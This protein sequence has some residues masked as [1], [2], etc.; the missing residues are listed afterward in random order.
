MGDGRGRAR[1]RLEARRGG[2]GPGARDAA[3]ALREVDMKRREFLAATGGVALSA[4]SSRRVLG[5][6]DRLGVALIGSGRR[7]REV[8]RAFLASGRAELRCVADV[9]DVQRQRAREALGVS[10]PE[11]VAHEEALARPGVDAVLIGVPDHLHLPHHPGRASPPASTSTWRNRPRT[12]STRAR[13]LVAAV[14]QVRQG[15]PDRHPAA[16]RRALRAGQGGVL[17]SRAARPRGLRPGR[18]E[19]LPVAAAQ[20][21]AAAHARRASTGSGSSGRR[22]RSRTTG[23]GYDSW[24]YFPDYGGGLLADILTHWVDVAQW[25]LN[26]A[27]PLNAV[28][29]GGIYQL[30]DGR[31]NPDTVSAVLQYAGGWNL[32]FESS[33]LPVVDPQAVGLLPGDGG[34]PGHRARRLR[35]PPEQGRGGRGQVEREP[36]ARAR[37]ELPRRREERD[38]PERGHRDRRPG[39]PAGAPGARSLLAP[40]ADAVRRVRQPG[41]KK[42]FSVT[43]VRP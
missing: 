1:R 13:S 27:R 20:D 28:A 29:T 16:Q 18:V 32:Q 7:G 8:M 33:V 42:T 34:Q 3:Q 19:R 5:A 31:E 21:R 22:R 41:S 26:E 11:V 17:R 12:P 39:V 6:N 10:A 40:E 14:R 2:S 43:H 15:L 25:F 38:A 23:S 35:V 9:Y 4:L 30:K 36:R 24:R 37:R